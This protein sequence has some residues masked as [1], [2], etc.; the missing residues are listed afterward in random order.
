MTPSKCLSKA[1][2]LCA[3]AVL[4]ILADVALLAFVLPKIGQSC[5]PLF[6]SQCNTNRNL[7]NLHLPKKQKLGLLAILSLSILVIL[8]AIIRVVRVLH[9]VTSQDVPW[10]SYDVDIWAAVEINT[11][12]FCVSA[13]A[14]KPLLRQLAP[15]LLSSSGA[16]DNFPT[17][18]RKC[19][20]GTARR[21]V[22]GTH[23]GFELSSQT[24]LDF[25]PK[26]PNVVNKSWIDFEP[27]SSRE[28]ESGGDAESERAIV[29]KDVRDGEIRKTVRVMVQGAKRDRGAVDGFECV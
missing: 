9:I 19:G 8:A 12:I 5:M 10:D 16:T 7:A 28:S 17:Y 23:Q 15:G 14:V 2:L 1:A 22:T 13:P 25:P 3:S 21:R 29:E 26:D 6:L 27:K 20:D 4:N 18:T 11:G 24:N